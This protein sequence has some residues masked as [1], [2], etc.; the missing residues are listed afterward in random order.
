MSSDTPPTGT[1]VKPAILFETA[2]ILVAALL[3]RVLET[4]VGARLH[5]DLPLVLLGMAVAAPPLVFLLW[6]LRS[7]WRPLAELREV[8]D[9]TVLPLFRGA[10]PAE[11][12]A[13]AV[14]AGVGEELL[15]RGVLQPAVAG[16]TTPWVGVA[17]VAALFGAVHW[18]TRVYALVAAVVG[19][20]FGAIVLVSGSVI[21]AI[22][23]HALYDM[24]ALGVLLRAEPGA[25]R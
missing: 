21:P 1:V 22:V 24:V 15:F 11:L 3:D 14:A 13:L 17:I 2:L 6:I 16:W 10:T 18:V 12:V 25:G 4:R 8:M 9:T 19:A 23:A 20:L 5:P 7:A